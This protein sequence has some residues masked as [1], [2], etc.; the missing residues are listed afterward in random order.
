M[1]VIKQ[2]VLAFIGLSVGATVAAGVFAFI[3]MLGIVPRLA[4]RT[5]TSDKIFWY[6]TCIII[7]GTLGNIWGVYRMAVPLSY[8]LLILFGFFSG[9][10]VGCLA[11]ALAE[12]LRVIPIFTI[13]MKL[14]V[15]IPLLLAG[16][17]LGKMAGGFFQFFFPS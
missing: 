11:M 4:A 8:P 17:G 7:G 3:T 1:I 10:Y 12:V 14:T 16:I 6:E 5:N 15:G 13:R 9:V 2:I